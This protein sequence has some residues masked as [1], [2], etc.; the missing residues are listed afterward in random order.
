[1]GVLLIHNTVL[2][3]VE[4]CLWALLAVAV[5]LIGYILFCRYRR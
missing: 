1:M 4:P 5:L 2:M 3:L